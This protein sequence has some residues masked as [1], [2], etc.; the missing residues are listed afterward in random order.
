MAADECLGALGSDTG[1]SVR[2][3]ASMSGVV[4]LKPSYGRVSRF[5]LVSYASSL[6]QIGTL[7]KDVMDAAILLGVIAGHDPYDATSMDAPVPRYT[8][9]FSSTDLAGV[10]LGVP[11]EYF[12]DGMQ[13]EVEGAVRAA[14]DLLAGLG[15]EVREVSLTHTGYALPAY[16]IIAPAEAS[17]NL[18]RY[19]GVRYGLRVP[20]DALGDMYKTTRGQGF[21]A[22]V[23]RR[24]MLGTHVLSAGVLRRLLPKGAAGA[25]TDQR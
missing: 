2:Q 3:P 17:A 25:H 13:P 20:Q 4:G 22:E 1:G 14:I 23:K 11:R 18:A 15:A 10:R 6:D 7:T 19:D 9:A 12:T 5:G 8:D 24:I 21:G 16:Y